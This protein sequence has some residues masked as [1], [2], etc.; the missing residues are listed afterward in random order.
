MSTSERYGQADATKERNPVLGR[1]H[2]EGVWFHKSFRGNECEIQMFLG[3]YEVDYCVYKLKEGVRH[4][5][6]HH[7]RIEFL[8][9]LLELRSNVDKVENSRFCLV[10]S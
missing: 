4:D 7:D 2:R 10:N 1:L 3:R 5:E 9:I 8:H 6:M